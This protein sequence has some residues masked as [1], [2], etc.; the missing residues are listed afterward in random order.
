MNIGK[1]EEPVCR[2]CLGVLEGLRTAQPDTY[3]NLFD[4]RPGIARAAAGCQ[5]SGVLGGEDAKLLEW[6]WDFN[7]RKGDRAE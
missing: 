5:E 7:S 6:N 1:L 2:R 3:G 4:G